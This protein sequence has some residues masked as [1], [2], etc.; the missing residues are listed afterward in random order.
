MIIE[1]FVIDNQPLN[2]KILESYINK[3]PFFKFTGSLESFEAYCNANIGADVLLI[4]V[5]VL[6]GD[7]LKLL[8]NMKKLLIFMLKCPRDDDMTDINLKDKNVGIL[9]LPAT[10]PLFLT[11]I[12]RLIK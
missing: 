10:Y 3:T 7:H 5:D 8:D 6:N 11:V 1:C 4:N 12:E 9:H 2:I